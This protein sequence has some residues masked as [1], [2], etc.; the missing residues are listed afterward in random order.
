[1]ER[2]D[3]AEASCKLQVGGS[4]TSVG[5]AEGMKALQQPGVL[6][7]PPAPALAA[8][9]LTVV[10]DMKVDINFKAV[11]AL[12]FLFYQNVTYGV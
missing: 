4:G 8:R 2:A 12:R 10:D 5:T 1:M 7:G 6:P 3:L 9:W 11:A